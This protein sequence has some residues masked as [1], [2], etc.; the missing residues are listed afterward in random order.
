[1]ALRSLLASLRQA[2]SATVMCPH[3]FQPRAEC[4]VRNKKARR[5]RIRRKHLPRKLGA[6]ASCRRVFDCD[7]AGR[8]PA[9][10]GQK[11]PKGAREMVRGV[12]AEAGRTPD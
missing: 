1:M 7:A 8:V 11:G 9:L 3:S 2:S 12:R 10:P 4:E 5:Q 6:P